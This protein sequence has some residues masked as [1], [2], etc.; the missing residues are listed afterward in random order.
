MAGCLNPAGT[1]WGPHWCMRHNIERM[2]RITQSINDV[3]TDYERRRGDS[4]RGYA[5]GLAGD[6]SPGTGNWDLWHG[7][8]AGKAKREIG[9]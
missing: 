2:D 8:R 3:V 1:W 5:R 9:G 4:A 6:P 7:W